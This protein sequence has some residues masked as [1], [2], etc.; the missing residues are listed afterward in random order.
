MLGDEVFRIAVGNSLLYIALAVPLRLVGALLTARLLLRPFRGA[1]AARA[2]VYLPTV[3]PDLAWSLVWMWILN[4]VY[5]PLN[6]MPAL[7][8]IAGPAWMTGQALARFAIVLMMAW[9]VGEGLV[10]CLAALQTVPR[11]LLGQ[12]AID[13][14]SPWWAFRGVTLPSIAPVRL[15]LLARDTIFSS[16]ANFVPALIVG[17]GGPDCATMFLPMYVYTTAFGC[18]RFGYAAA[19]T[20]TMYAVTEVVLWLLFR[21]AAR[22]RS[23][24]WDGVWLPASAAGGVRRHASDGRGAGGRAVPAAAGLGGLDLAPANRVAAAAQRPGRRRRWRGRTTG[25]SFG[26]SMRRGSWRTRCS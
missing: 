1:P 16:Q 3:I 25:R 12:A 6:Q 14:S 7:A 17:G 18:L 19:M 10:V 24:V 23:G 4:P 15:V 26:S 21:A 22:W 11:D 2:A 20:G 13:G 5:G 8:G 9:Q